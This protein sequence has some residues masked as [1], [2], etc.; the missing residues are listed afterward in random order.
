M[1]MDAWHALGALECPWMPGMPVDA[2]DPLNAHGAKN[3]ISI[4]RFIRKTYWNNDGM[5]WA[6][7]VKMY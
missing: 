3:G 5:L 4:S 2:R 1:P 6:I 7:I